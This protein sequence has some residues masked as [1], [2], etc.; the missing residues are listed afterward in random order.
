MSVCHR[1]IRNRL[2]SE[3][4]SSPTLRSDALRAALSS[5]GTATNAALYLLLRA[6]DRFTEANHRAPGTEPQ[7]CEADVPSLKSFCGSILSESGAQNASSA[8]S[9][10]L[11]GEQKNSS[12]SEEHYWYQSIVV[13]LNYQCL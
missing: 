3:E 11:L 10:D 7:D 5:E 4:V 2:I 9:D 12:V 6:V 8:I 13:V 1:V